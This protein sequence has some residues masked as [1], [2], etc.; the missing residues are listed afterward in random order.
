MAQLV[1]KFTGGITPEQLRQA[2]HP[3]VT[4]PIRMDSQLAE[5]ITRHCGK[6]RG[7]NGPAKFYEEAIRKNLEDL[8]CILLAAM[9]CKGR[10]KHD[11]HRVSA[12]HLAIDVAEM[13][14]QA[15]TFPKTKGYTRMGRG[16]ILASCALLHADSLKL[17]P[18]AEGEVPKTEAG[19]TITVEQPVKAI[20]EVSKR[21]YNKKAPVK[22]VAKPVNK[23]SKR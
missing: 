20:L 7:E 11:T 10:M 12:I 2:T 16:A 13:L 19:K 22:K 17:L 15:E 5:A 23:K 1:F 4:I 21:P 8:D 3:T 14:K 6:S 9:E 18:E